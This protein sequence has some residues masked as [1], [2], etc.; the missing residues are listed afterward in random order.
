M[1]SPDDALASSL[2]SVKA[3][4]G[5]ALGDARPARTL[6]LKAT[7]AWSGARDPF[8]QVRALDQASASLFAIEA[9]SAGVGAVNLDFDSNGEVRRM[10]LVFRLRDKTVP[11]LEAEMLRLHESAGLGRFEGE[12]LRR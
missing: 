7:V 3:V 2:A 4:T 5:F 12:T 6:T 1:P 11:S 10:P 8:G 9:A